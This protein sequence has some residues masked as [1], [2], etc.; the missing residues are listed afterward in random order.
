MEESLL[1]IIELNVGG[2]TYATTMGTLQQAESDSPLASI[3]SVPNNSD[4]RT[5]FGRDSK[6]RVFIDRDGVLF[7]Y[8][9]DYLRNQ[10]LALPENFSERDRLRVEAEFYRLTGLVQALKQVRSSHHFNGSIL[11]TT[12][13]VNS[14]NLNATSTSS[15]LPPPRSTS[16]YIVVGYRGTFGK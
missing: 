3:A 12:S 5:T 2:V 7:R 13:G 4:T 16:G 1:D 11:Q 6:N 10:K 14:M 8:I 9:L 15:R